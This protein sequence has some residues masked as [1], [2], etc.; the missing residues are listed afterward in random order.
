MKRLLF[1]III[2][3]IKRIL[4]N[5]NSLGFNRQIYVL[6]SR[7]VLR[8]NQIRHFLPSLI[9]SKDDFKT[10]P[11]L[12]GIIADSSKLASQRILR[13]GKKNLT[14]SKFLNVFPGEHYR[15]LNAIV[16]TSNA[17]KIVEIGTYTGMG[18][19]SL[20]EGFKDVFVTTYDIIKWDELPV[21]S[22]FESKDFSESINQ[23]IGDLSDDKFF[24]SNL[25]ILNDADLIFMD[26]PK[27][28]IFE[29]KM[30]QNFK[31]LKNKNKKLLIIDDILFVNMID[32][33]RKI[34]SPKVDASSF[35]HWSGT[36]IVDISDGFLFD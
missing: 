26:A 34:K 20:K 7:Y 8:D 10:T 25:E 36:G 14:D 3:I 22:H 35:G 24:E 33:W 15:L 29:Y 32:F 5:S 6:L 30:A 16:E 31:K 11:E 28:N 2:G 9:Y 19:L 12:V 1:G 18:T 4:D 13:C 21:P 23:V 17:K 27:D